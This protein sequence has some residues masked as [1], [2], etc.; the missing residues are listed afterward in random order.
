MPS[1]YPTLFAVVNDNPDR[2]FAPDELVICHDND[3]VQMIYR[4]REKAISQRDRQREMFDNP[5]INVRPIEVGE[6]VEP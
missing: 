3:G 4:D 1:S 6:V 2:R 5:A